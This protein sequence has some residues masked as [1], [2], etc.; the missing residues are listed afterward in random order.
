MDNEDCLVVG[1]FTATLALSAVLLFTVQPLFGKQLLPLLGGAPSVW[2]VCLVFFQTTLLAGYLYS[3]LMSTRLGVRRQVIVHAAVS[4]LPLAVLPL[5]VAG[6]WQPP[7]TGGHVIWLLGLLAVTVGPPFFVVSTNAPLLQRW[8]SRTSHPLAHDPYFLYAAS[9]AGSVVGLLSY[10]TLIEPLLT[11]AAQAFWWAIGYGLL[12]VLTA[13]CA[14]A[15]WRGNPPTKAPSVGGVPAEATAVPHRS[16]G[17]APSGIDRGRWFIQSAVPASLLLGV[18]TYITTD[19]GSF[20]LLWVV[21][22]ALYLLTFV[23]AFARR[24]VVSARQA[25][26]LLPLVVVPAVLSFMLA[27]GPGT[28]IWIP[29]HLLAFVVAAAAAHGRLAE[30]RPAGR[31]LTEF[32]VWISAGGVAG[33]LVNALLAPAVLTGPFEYPAMLAAACFLRRDFRDGDLWGRAVSRTGP[34]AGGRPRHPSLD[35]VLPIGLGVALV[36]FR[37]VAALAGW[38]S[39]VSVVVSDG[40]PLAVCALLSPWRL[41]FGLGVASIVVAGLAAGG[42]T[43]AVLFADRSFFGVIRVTED[44]SGRVRRL[45]HGTTVHGAQVVAPDRRTEPTSYYHRRGPLGDVFA[46]ATGRA[47]NTRV[48]VVG[49]GTGATACHGHSDQRWTFFEID[50]TIVE[51]AR[52][53]RLFSYL[54]DCRPSVR[55]VVGDG[56]RSLEREPDGVYDL[57]VVDAFGSDAI[58]VHLVTREAVDLYRR[59]LASNGWLVVHISNRYVDLEPVLG[60]IGRLLGL[61]MATRVDGSATPHPDGWLPSTWC[62]LADDEARLRSQFPPPRWRP[63]PGRASEPWTDDYA[64]VLTA[65]KG[66]PR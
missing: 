32:F 14:V 3:H 38:S 26:A 43:D 47:E 5:G 49:L 4:L 13:A 27:G 55:V 54:R 33:S 19:L 59:K 60:R 10:P 12:L 63:P 24:P 51:V 39:L 28:T 64:P 20:P 41:R 45:A 62:V 58:P 30:S 11:R 52:D 1:L 18:T 57:L 37:S 46:T 61:A 21:P 15:M 50:P 48:G 6:D 42:G 7:V 40:V 2:N 8:F 22:L 17:R 9:N 56:R 53:P 25:S 16:D 23:N 34:V 31:W 29:V 65:V 36:L 66:W 44:A 35:L